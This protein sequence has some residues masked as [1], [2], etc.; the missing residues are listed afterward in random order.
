[1]KAGV[2]VAWITGAF[3]FASMIIGI[4]CNRSR[5][6]IQT[7][8]N[9]VYYFSDSPKRKVISSTV[10]QKVPETIKPADVPI[11][12]KKFTSSS[13][14]DIHARRKI[15]EKEIM[16]DMNRYFPDRTLSVQFVSFDEANTEV[17]SVKN[18]ITAIL[19]KNGY[20]NIEVNFHLKKGAIVPEKIV[21]DSI[22]G[23]HSIYFAIPPG[24]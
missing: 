13:K 1:M 6:K 24:N 20:K 9:T 23:R 14:Y 7:M 17:M 22:P 21:L 4:I 18:R 12:K 11:H 5:G 19:K 3:I 15:S 2:Q 8:N 10:Q 16:S